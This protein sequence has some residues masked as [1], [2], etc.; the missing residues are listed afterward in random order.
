MTFAISQLAMGKVPGIDGLPGEWY[1]WIV[2]PWNKYRPLAI[3][4]LMRVFNKVLSTGETPKN[5]TAGVLSILYKNKGDPEDIRNYRPLTVMNV[6]YKIFTLIIMKRILIPLDYVL[7]AH[8]TAFLPGRLIDDGVRTVQMLIARY[9]DSADGINMIFLDQE[10]AYDRVSHE[11]LWAALERIGVPHRLIQCFRGLYEGAEVNLYVNG[12]K[13]DSIK[14]RCGVR[15]GDSLSCPLFIIGMYLS[16]EGRVLIANTLM[17]SIPRYAL[18]FL[19]LPPSV[20]R[21]LNKEYF[22][23]VWD[24]KAR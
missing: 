7:G 8:Q 23:M 20:K 6:D 3:S 17:M 11:F 21:E 13:S 14:V 2:E 10:K 19:S 1:K 18:R 24:D 9:R 5:W 12:E 4:S 15:Q 16:L 22:R